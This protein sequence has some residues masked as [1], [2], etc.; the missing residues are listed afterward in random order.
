MWTAPDFHIVF[1]STNCYLTCTKVFRLRS[2]H[3]MCTA[4]VPRPRKPRQHLEQ[5]LPRLLKLPGGFDMIDAGC[6]GC[7]LCFIMLPAAHTLQYI[8]TS[9]YAGS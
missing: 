3:I 8:C 5:M 9:I 4:V 6:L 7:S 1:G 2:T